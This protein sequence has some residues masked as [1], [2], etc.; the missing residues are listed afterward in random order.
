M[1][2]ELEERVLKQIRENPYA[3]QQGM[4]ENLGLPRSTLAGVIS[5][6]TQKRYLLGKAYVLND[7]PYIICIGAMN[8]DRKFT[9]K[10][11]LVLGTSNPVTST[12]AVGGVARN[13]SEN[14]GR[15]G[16]DV[17]LLSLA[18]ADQDFQV[19]KNNTEAYVN[20]QEVNQ[21]AT[22]A[23]ST[24]TAILDEKGDMQVAYADMDICDLMTREWIERYSA[25]LKQAKLIVIDLNIPLETTQWVIDFAKF[26]QIP[27][28]VVPVSELKMNHLPQKLD[29]VEWI[30]VN[31]GESLQYLGYQSNV[32]ISTEQLAKEWLNHG[33]KNVL[34]TQ[35]SEEIIH[36]SESKVTVYPSIPVTKVCDVT[37]AGDSFS[38]GLIFGLY[39][40]EDVEKSIQLGLTNANK[41]IQS[42]LTVRLE[43]NAEELFQSWEQ[44]FKK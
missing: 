33:V 3:S 5:G 43:L 38:S 30:V 32:H 37:G 27:L 6:L 44:I 28:I 15:M 7:A 29:G 34:I 41:T 8:V 4:A 11:Q 17:R 12:L 19:I 36:A 2:S 9:L 1:L 21:I 16:L 20:L 22:S 10:E 42:N 24:Y 26:N 23:T 25:L 39:H 35:G 13:I 18:G 14:L 31:R 40:G